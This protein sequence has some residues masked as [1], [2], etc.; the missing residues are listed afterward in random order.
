MLKSTQTSEEVPENA[1]NFEL[2]EYPEGSERNVCQ[3]LIE[4]EINPLPL[5]NLKDGQTAMDAPCPA[6]G[7]IHQSISDAL[8]TI[9]AAVGVSHGVST[10][11]IVANEAGM[12]PL[13]GEATN[14]GS[15]KKGDAIYLLNE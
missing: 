9:Q 14:V 1:G 6:T 13:L 10:S 2:L 12:N 4:A 3:E 5:S 15:I 11:L 8:V 7:G